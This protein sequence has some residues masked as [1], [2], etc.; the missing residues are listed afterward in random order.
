VAAIVP[1]LSISWIQHGHGVQ[2]HRR[3]A[4]YSSRQDVNDDRKHDLAL[5]DGYYL[6]TRYQ[7][8]SQLKEQ[9]RSLNRSSGTWID[10]QR[11]NGTILARSMTIGFSD[12]DATL[13]QPH[14]SVMHN[15]L[16]WVN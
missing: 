4:A 3:F 5:D 12:P 15:L 1:R 16:H 14:C 2:S 8:H 7:H 11:K 13:E 6:I 10:L 9:R